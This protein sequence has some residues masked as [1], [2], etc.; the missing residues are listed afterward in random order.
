MRPSQKV[1]KDCPSSAMTL[2]S[3]S[4]EVSRRTALITPIG[5]A[6]TRLTRKAVVPSSSVSGRRSITIVNAGRR[7]LN[8]SPKLPSTAW[9]R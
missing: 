1:G 5:T 9:P 6:I 7:V 4:T 8:E 2:P 3:M